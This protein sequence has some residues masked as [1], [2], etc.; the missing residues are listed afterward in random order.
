MSIGSYREFS[1]LALVGVAGARAQA[2]INE[3]L[4]ARPFDSLAPSSIPY[5]FLVYVLFSVSLW[6]QCGI[7]VR[8]SHA[9]VNVATGA[10]QVLYIYSIYSHVCVSTHI[11]VC[12]C[13]CALSEN[14]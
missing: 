8:K 4:C 12:V 9:K 7:Q 1:R 5:V 3:S 13:V 11:Y 2:L 10:A 14:I 6:M